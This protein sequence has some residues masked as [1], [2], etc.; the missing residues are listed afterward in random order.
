[1]IAKKSSVGKIKTLVENFEGTENE[2]LT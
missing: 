2:D 1:L